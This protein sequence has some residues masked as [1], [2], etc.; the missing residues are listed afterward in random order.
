[1]RL[2]LVAGGL[3]TLV[4]CGEGDPAK[5][6]IVYDATCDTCHGE[7]GQ[8]GVLT[9]ST[10]A[11]DLTEEVPE[12][13]DEELTDIIKNGYGDMAPVDVSS[14]DIK[15]LIAYLREQFPG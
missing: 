4:A 1:M 13:S 7:D 11:A 3:L 12:K 6:K 10:P 8:A 5:G 14:G 15:H 2:A 9:G